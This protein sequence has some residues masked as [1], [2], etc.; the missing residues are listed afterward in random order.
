MSQSASIGSAEDSATFVFQVTAILNAN[1][2]TQH[3]FDVFV[4]LLFLFFN[5]SEEEG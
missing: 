3:Y 4:P 1:I 2:H 5:L